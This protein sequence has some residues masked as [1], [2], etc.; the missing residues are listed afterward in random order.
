MSYVL[1]AVLVPVAAWSVA[2]SSPRPITSEPAQESTCCGCHVAAPDAGCRAVAR[3]ALETTRP[4]HEAHLPASDWHRP[5]RCDSCH[6]LPAAV[7]APGHTDSALPAEV[8]LGGLAVANGSPAQYEPESH[9]CTSYCHGATLGAA[10]PIVWQ[11][12]KGG[13][14]CDACHGMPPAPPHMP[15][16]DCSACHETVDAERVFVA[17]EQHID[18]VLQLKEGDCSACHGTPGY[19]APP[20]GINGDRATTARGVGAHRQHLGISTWHAP[21]SCAECHVVPAT[22]QAPGH[23]DTP[24]PAELSWG[25]LSKAG[26]ATPSFNADTLTC[27]EVYCHAAGP[28]RGGSVPEPLWTRVDGTQAACGACHGLPPALRHVART[29]CVACHGMVVD[30][31]RA[32]VAP[33][34]HVNGQVDVEPAGCSG[35]HGG[36]ANAAPP[37]STSGETATTAIAVGAHQRHL[38]TD[39]QHRPITCESCHQVPATV[40]ADGHLDAAPAEVRFGPLARVDDAA[41]TFDREGASCAVYCHGVTLT[42]A[43][44]AHPEPVW[45]LV[46]GTQTTCGGCH[47]FPPGGAH[48]PRT[49]CARCHGGGMTDPTRHVD[50]HLDVGPLACDSCHGEAQNA[51]PPPDLSGSRA[52]SGRGVGAHAAHLQPSTRHAAVSCADCHQVPGFVEA[53]GHADTAG[54]AEIIWG[55]RAQLHGAEPEY[56]GATGTCRDTYCHGATLTGGDAT[57]PVWTVVDGSQRACGSCHGMPPSSNHPES[58]SCSRCHPQ[59]VA[60]DL[61]FVTPELHVNGHVEVATAC[62]AC[63]GS[64]GVAA[65]PLDL[66]DAYM[67]T[68]P[69]VGAHRTHL[70][71]T[72]THGPVACQQCHQVPAFVAAAGHL[73]L[74]PG[75]ELTFGPLASYGGAKPD[76]DRAQRRCS[77][78]YCHGATFAGGGGATPSPVWNVVDGSQTGCTGCH[79][80]PPAGMHP[81]RPECAM[82]H[83]DV[84]DAANAIIAPTR[85]VDGSIDLNNGACSNCHGGTDNAA[86]PA[87][88]SG[89][90]ETT[91]RGVG[92]HQAHLQSSTW[93]AAIACGRCHLVPATFLDRGHVDSASPAEVV[94]SGIATYWGASYS[95]VPQACSVY[96]HR[97]GGASGG[98]VPAPTWTM[99]GGSAGDCGACHGLPPGGGHPGRA[100][101]ATCHPDVIDSGGAII[102]AALHIDGGAQWLHPPPGLDCGDCHHGS[103]CSDCH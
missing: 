75:A 78:T 47:G 85:H 25:G 92:A 73:D 49:D 84:V 36:E 40:D 58:P 35:C 74:S 16:A 101:C 30:A 32:F 79:G 51:A 7:A 20:V 102:Q 76:Y 89:E 103:V 97:L 17:P 88:L 90:A 53:A 44:G 60:A 11:Q 77:E 93:R 100:D 8:V 3:Y 98:S 50:G 43:G 91:D 46:D 18:G 81:P 4:I 96:C 39:G 99:Q 95:G 63:H 48:P 86:P 6:Q 37:G 12:V 66:S 38:Q 24:P 55:T 71:G 21:I 94:F 15:R 56:L 34:L 82:C 29:D 87:A 2:C 67:T 68:A 52:T 65:P 19:P 83:G 80:M 72:A 9:T 57:A 54:P 13:L 42:A 33:A 1:R 45:T 62:D 22:P 5:V 23:I 10:H 69:G 41:A 27:A 28:R 70:D 64:A 14:A 31:A 61:S 59:V 26:G